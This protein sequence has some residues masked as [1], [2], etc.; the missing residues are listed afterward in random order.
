[1]ND[2]DSSRFTRARWYWTAPYVAVGVFALTMLA[3]VW[4]LQTREA[5][6]ERNAVARD[7]QWAEQTMRRHMQ[8]TEEFLGQLARDLAADALDMDGFQ[9][10]ANQHIANNAE[11][12]NIV[13]VG[14]EEAV[15]WSA[16]FD[17]TDWLVGDG[18]SGLQTQAF[19]RARELSRPSYGAPYAN[20]RD[21]VVLEVYVP[22]RRGRE[23]LGAVV[24]VYSIDRMVRHLVPSWFA[25]KYRLALISDKGESLAVNSRVRDLD[26]SVSYQI[27]LDP[28]GNGL[29][30]RATAFRTGSQ[31]PQALPTAMILGLSVIVLLSLWLLRTHVQRRVQV[32]KERDRLFN[33]SLDLLCIVGLDGVFRRANP[34]FE[35]I[36]GYAP[37]DLPGRPLLDLVHPDDVSATVEQ[38]RRLSGGEPVSLENR[39]RCVDGSFKWLAWSINPVRE[40]KLVYAVAHDITGRKAGEDALRAESSFRKAMEESV[41]TGMRAI[42]L[43]GRIIY[44]NAAFC[45]MV[46][47]E[48]DELIGVSRPFP[49]WPLEDLQLC[50]DNLDLTLLGR[51]PPGGFEMRI[52]RKNGERLDARFYLSPLIDNSGTQTGWMASVTDITEPKRIRAA[53]EAAHERF[54]AVLDGLEAAV[55]VAD[56]GSDEILFA[57]RAFKSI[58]GFDAVGRTVQGVAV[59]Q[60]E[61][62]D[63]RL[64]PHVLKPADVPR[65]LF[66]GELQHP[67]SGRWYHVRERATRWVDGRVVRMGIATDITERKQTAE[68]S[69][70][71]AERLQRTSRLITM[72]EMAS[73][74]AHELNQPLAAIAN[75]CMGCVTRIQAGN[76]R[77]EDL[78]AAM[79]KASFQAER[80]GKIIRRVREFVKKSEPRRSAVQISEVLDDA[81]GFAEIDAKRM[82]SRIVADVAAGLPAVFADRIMIEQ[83]VLNLVKNGLDSMADLPRDQRV[84]VVGARA[85]GPS[86][87]EVSVIDRG[88]GIDEDAHAH[89]FTPFYTTKAEGMGMGLNICRSIIEFHDGRLVVDSNPEGGTIFS[90]TLPTEV[91]S[92][93]IA[94]RV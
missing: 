60:P 91:A 19:Y 54:E 1:M 11:L 90:F 82:S 94:R 25:E 6:S 32:E 57:N 89:L 7:V 21:K 47:F 63:Y 44:V 18:L 16:P 29:T 55:F 42:D 38:M 37:N 52:R 50:S 78:L 93:P 2:I 70:Q 92:E 79:Q 41:V 85:L 20:P 53:L 58:H 22:A 83:V 61:R 40:E 51:A 10:R 46:G 69:R 9:V 76:V 30:L 77:G 56:A 80:A 12:V 81:I 67:L 43:D 8:G 34:A 33:L 35:R 86:A 64:D 65:E 66:D 74:L 27:P 31:L 88:H 59:L 4:L 39:C 71:Q 26:E 23:F 28:P 48:P 24:G 45:R 84:L 14:P 87:V 3:L 36:L 72:G 17:T 62:G 75:Y 73:T 15:R 5:E 13:W 68:V 49:Y